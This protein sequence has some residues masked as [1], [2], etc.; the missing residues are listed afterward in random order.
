MLATLS[1][2]FSASTNSSSSTQTHPVP[3]PASIPTSASVSLAPPAPTGLV[4]SPHHHSSANGSFI[5]CARTGSSFNIFR[6]RTPPT[7]QQVGTT[8]NTS[9]ASLGPSLL[10]ERVPL[11]SEEGE[12]GGRRSASPFHER[13]R[14][15]SC[16]LGISPT[17]GLASGSSCS[18]SG[19]SIFSDHSSTSTFSRISTSP[20]KNFYSAS[21]SSTSPSRCSTPSPSSVI[22]VGAISSAVSDSPKRRKVE[23]VS[24]ENDIHSKDGTSCG[25]CLEAK[26][27]EQAKLGRK[28]SVDEAAQVRVAPTANDGIVDHTKD[29]V[30][31]A[32]AAF[33]PVNTLQQFIP[34]ASSSLS[35]SGGGGVGGTRKARPKRLNL[36][37]PPGSSHSN[38]SNRSGQ[39]GG[40]DAKDGAEE[41][42]TKA[43]ASGSGTR[44][45]PVSPSLVLSS[46]GVGPAGPG[47]SGMSGSVA[48][49]VG[50]GLG[51]GIAGGVGSPEPSVDPVKDLSS[52]LRGAPRRRPSMP[53]RTSVSSGVGSAGGAGAAPSSGA[54]GGGHIGSGVG[55]GQNSARAG[56]PSLS[57]QT[58]SKMLGGPMQGGESAATGM[59]GNEGL[60]ASGAHASLSSTLTPRSLI[61]RVPEAFRDPSEHILSG[62]GS[63]LQ[64]ARS[65][66]AS[67]P[68]EILPGLFLGDEHNAR[69]AV[70]LSELNITTILDV[71]KETSLPGGGAEEVVGGGKEVLPM[72]A[73]P[74][75]TPR[76]EQQQQQ[77]RSSSSQT[78]TSSPVVPLT[79][80]PRAVD[81]ETPSSSYGFQEG[82]S[83]S[84]FQLSASNLPVKTPATAYFTPPTTAYPRHLPDEVPQTPA[85]KEKSN[86]PPPLVADGEKTPY[87]RNTL[88]TPNL[89]RYG[90]AGR[91]TTGKQA[92]ASQRRIRKRRG[93]AGDTTSSVSSSSSSSDGSDNADTLMEEDDD[94]E[95]GA[96]ESNTSV[97]SKPSSPEMTS[98]PEGYFPSGT[99]VSKGDDGKDEERMDIDKPAGAEDEDNTLR[100]R[101]H[102]GKS[103]WLPSN[104]IALMF[105]PSPVSGRAKETRYIKLPWTHD[106]T[107]LAAVGGGFT[108]GCAIIA[109]ALGIPPRL[110]SSGGVRGMRKGSSAVGT[111]GAGAPD[112]VPRAPSLGA[113]AQGD[114]GSQSSDDGL[115]SG[116]DR[117]PGVLVHCQC[118]VS[119]SAT[120]VIAF[121]MQ[122][123]ALMYGFEGVS[124]LTGMHDC[125]NLVKE[126]SASISPNCSLI[127][128]LV[129]WERF[130]SAEATK[131]RKATEKASQQA[132]GGIEGAS[133]QNTRG[134]TSEV[135]D[136]EEW[137]RMRLEEERKEADEEDR[138]R[139]V[140]LEEALQAAR[141]KAAEEAVASSTDG[142][143]GSPAG[144]GLGARRKKKAPALSL[145]GGPKSTIA[146]SAAPPPAVTAA[147]LALQ[148]TAEAADGSAVPPTPTVRSA[149]PPLGGRSKMRPS[150]LHID[151]AAPLTSAMPSLSLEST[152][153]EEDGTKRQQQQERP[154]PSLG[155]GAKDNFGA[156]LSARLLDAQ[157]TPTGTSRNSPHSNMLQSSI[158]VPGTSLPL[159]RLSSV[160]RTEDGQDEANPDLEQ[161]QQAVKSVTPHRPP[162]DRRKSVQVVMGTTSSF[163]GAAAQSAADRKERHRRTF[164]SDWPAPNMASLKAEVQAAA[165]KAAALTRQEWKA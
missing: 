92:S 103:V 38:R 97:S 45:V 36:V 154:T 129:E 11:P 165:A 93:E 137:T 31:Q 87:L 150:H 91:G 98:V 81:G 18:S 153:E 47:Q 68:V 100:L 53:F 41:W 157:K 136:E 26:M 134:W 77:Q 9:A 128:Q 108:Q 70:R 121:V 44:S 6:S 62:K 101:D 33:A 138:L 63:T 1:P 160:R 59:A 46:A 94:D 135:L 86:A 132:V 80:L 27:A 162:S 143:D 14:R 25:H 115:Q 12:H 159:S 66:Y 39:L 119:R 48:G 54:G 146:G 58:D 50:P 161:G 72:F 55:T 10:A 125:Y 152:K 104:A 78:I 123:A 74:L 61:A 85:S 64:H 120:L 34:G 49:G 20:V 164:S 2:N 23:L 69:D 106:E 148:T 113:E 37:P 60:R 30:T 122:A 19:D 102:R 141:R 116:Q 4:L 65:I 42:D 17:V 43:A 95:A 40:G 83:L 131:L 140:R 112:F 82:M 16:D 151:P 110:T 142:G 111:L 109:D 105:P 107:E 118:G 29:Q 144:T 156:E 24:E 7:L 22:L 126:K 73:I 56:P 133:G 71:A 13:K 52:T 99:G 35:N 89:Q 51:L 149:L 124:S 139:K 79:S 114:G 32:P 158:S 127:Y 28:L 96:T 76:F 130:L 147:S 67:G 5:G 163:V 145:G 84:S 90:S 21:S 8:S 88:S 75:R 155:S 3:V 57:I 15:A 117:P